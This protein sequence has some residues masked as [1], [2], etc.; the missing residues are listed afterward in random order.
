MAGARVDATEREVSA[1]RSI[2]ELPGPPGLPLVGSAHRMRLYDTHQVLEQWC[3]RYGPIFTFRAGLRRYVAVG[4]SETINQVL[5]ER[6]DGFRRSRELAN[7]FEGV[8]FPGVLTVEGE[9]WK[10][11]RRLVVTALNTNRLH[12]HFQV[13]RTATER[14]H[15]RLLG[16]A[17]EDRS[18][19]IGAALTSYTVDIASALAFGHDLNTLERGDNELQS[20][21]QRAFN[22]LNRRSLFPLPYWRW[23]RLPADRALDRSLVQLRHATAGFIAQARE[24]LAER[25]ELREE[26]ENFLQAMLAAQQTEGTFT[27]QEII[28][29]VFTL[30]LAGED[31]TAHT[32]SWTVWFLAQKPEIQA[33]WAQE[34]DIVLGERPFPEEHEQISQLP[35]G[36]AVL[37]ES[38]RLKGVAPVIGLESLADTTVADTRIPAGTRVLLLGRYASRQAGGAEFEPGRWLDDHEREAP[39]QK[40]FLA[41]GAGPRFCPGRNLAFLEASAA[42]AMIARNFELQL[43]QEG[44]PVREQFSLTMAPRGLRMRLRERATQTPRRARAAVLASVTTNGCPAIVGGAREP[45]AS[46]GT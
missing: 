30:L 5:R 36:A 42:L 28:G 14:L 11:Q 15:R 9:T 32:I 2:V 23:I 39:D 45:N 43:D 38:M 27:D 31:T 6:P 13:I 29:N 4:E 37:R 22:M 26:P 40:S 19:Q 18:I 44:G 34:A 8:G 10:R 16:A 3:E 33:R 25:P 17:R 7:A 24:Q 1:T 12:R 20:H 46:E 35:Y 41:F 21:I